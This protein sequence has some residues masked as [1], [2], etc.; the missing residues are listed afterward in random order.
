MAYSY[1]TFT[2]AIAQLAQRLYDTSALRF[3]TDTELGLYI[4]EALR[5]WNSLANFWRDDFTFPTVNGTVWYDITNTT[6]APNTLRPFSVSDVDIYKQMQYHLLEPATGATW[7]G[8]TQF[9]IDDLLKAV[10]RRRDEVLSNTACTITRQTTAAAAG[11]TTLS[12]S[13]IDIRRVAW[14]PNANIQGYVN[15]P[16]WPDDIYGLE[17]YERGF[18][19]AAAGNPSTYRRSSE[20]PL[21]FEADIPPAVAGNYEVLSVNAGSALSTGAPTNLVVPNDFTWVVKFGAMADLLNRA[22]LSRDSVRAQY[23]NMR[24]AQG[25]AML[26]QAPACL[27][28]K[29]GTTVLD[30]DAVQSVDN[31]RPLWQSLTAAQPDLAITAGLNLLGFAATPNGAYTVTLTVVQ[32]APVPSIGSDNIQLGRDELDAVLDYAQHL[33]SFKMGGSEF[34]ATIPL[35]QRFMKQAALYNSKLNAMGEY[36]QPIYELSQLQSI[37]NPV[38]SA[39]TPANADGGNQ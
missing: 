38:F 25:L 24:Y 4:I 33:A 19:A 34:I 17:A 13:V 36:T 35:F 6:T 37:A 7:T 10:Q 22:S 30:I 1:I 9:V 8:S 39:T 11:R 32:N 28:A 20:P 29:I 27:A 21:N 23:C 12:D 15:T 26:L 14:L 18:L 2:Q 5:T 31:Y 3:W 16:L